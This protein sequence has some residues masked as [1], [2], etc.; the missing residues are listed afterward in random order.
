MRV[1]LLIITAALVLA[2]AIPVLA[3][4]SFAAEFDANKTT[5]L[6]GAVTKL[7]WINPHARL[8]V[9][10]KGGDGKI[11]AWEI[12]LGPP[13]ILMRS[14]WTKNRIGRK[15]C[16]EGNSS[17]SRLRARC[18]T[19]PNGCSW[20]RPPPRS[21]MPARRVSTPCYTNACQIPALSVPATTQ[22]SRSFMRGDYGSKTTPR[23]SD[24]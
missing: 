22:T 20:M 10:V 1:R 8:F 13:A 9:D 6:T 19:N 5:T 11:T 4:H 24:I 15:C 18:F 14:G 12:E 17:A 2:A 21:T 23:V 16:P 7:D 3:H